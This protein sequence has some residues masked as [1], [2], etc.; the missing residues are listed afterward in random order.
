MKNYIC[1]PGKFFAKFL[2]V[3]SVSFIADHIF[4]KRKIPVRFKDEWRPPESVEGYKKFRVISC[5]VRKKYVPQFEEAMTELKNVMP[6]FGY[7][8]YSRFCYKLMKDIDDYKER[9]NKR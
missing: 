6:V 3:D 1:F 2:Y 7:P 4:I 8:E 5:R 9:N